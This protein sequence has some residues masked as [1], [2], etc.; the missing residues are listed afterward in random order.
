MNSKLPV[1]SLILPPKV[2]E[3]MFDPADLDRLKAKATLFGPFDGT[4]LSGLQ[5]ALSESTAILTGWGSPQFDE[6]LLSVARKLKLIAHSAGSVKPIVSDALYNRGVKVTT[7]ASANALPVA[8]FTIAMMIAMLKQ[9]FWLAPAHKAADKNEIL[10]RIEQ[11]RDLTRTTVGLI[12]ASRVGREVIKLLHSFSDLKIKVHDPFLT[13]DE[14]KKLRVEKAS[15]EDICRCPIVSVHAPNLPETRHLLNEKNLALLPDHAIFINTSRGS[16]ID[17]AALVA[18]VRKRPLYV[19]LDVTDPEPPTPDSPLR[20]EKNILLTGHMAGAMQAAR[21]DMGKLA[22]DE[23]IRFL[24]N[25]P[26]QHEVTKQMLS[27]QS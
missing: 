14:A 4:D 24:S 3:M 13:D 1:V 7:A 11:V 6:Q 25:Q 16:I 8:Q 5:L 9:V 2:A 12:S 21:K 22:I 17:E 27:T 20:T 19:L 26:L 15:L 18:E 10:A 23:V